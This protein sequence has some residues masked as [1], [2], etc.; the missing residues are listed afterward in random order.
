MADRDLVKRLKE[1]GTDCWNQWRERVPDVVVDLTG[2]T[3]AGANFAGAD[4]RRA[5]L[6]GAHLGRADFRGA[7][8]TGARLDRA[9]LK[10]AHLE[11]VDLGGAKGLV[12][13]QIDEACGDKGTKL[14]PG[15][16]RPSHWVSY[17]EEKGWAFAQTSIS[18]KQP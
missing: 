15:L 4:L 13:E 17:S 10:G 18:H 1:G 5:Y 7:N 16:R 14:P 9:D 8:L 2:A 3:F 6:V 12:Q 11:G